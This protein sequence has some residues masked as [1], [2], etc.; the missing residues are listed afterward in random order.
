MKR[1]LLEKNLVLILFV[2]VFVIFSFAE[3]DSR[4]L[5]KIYPVSQLIKKGS[6][7]EK[8]IISPVSYLLPQPISFF[9]K[10]DKCVVLLIQVPLYNHKKNR[11][12]ALLME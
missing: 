1:K 10:Q 9:H 6:D 4:K 3:R 5:E 2:M 12:N 11:N 7:Q 8:Y